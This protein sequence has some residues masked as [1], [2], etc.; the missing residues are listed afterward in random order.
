[1]N[2][3]TWYATALVVLAALASRQGMMAGLAV[4]GVADPVAGIVGRRFGRHKLRSG[5]SLEG[6]LAFVASGA[7]AAFAG[8]ALLGVSGPLPAW[9]LAVGGALVGALAELTSG[10]LDDNF[11][12]P[13][14]VGAA[15]TLATLGP[16]P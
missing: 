1:V 2:S 15:I 5:K 9:V 16:I 6:S 4:L 13:V 7:L 12:I 14:A 3:A 8:L 10:A 11:T